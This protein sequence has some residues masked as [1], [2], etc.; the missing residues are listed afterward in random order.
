ML[1]LEVIVPSVNRAVA[2]DAEV[3]HHNAGNVESVF[4]PHE[5]VHQHA[6]TY[7]ARFLLDRIL[8][9]AIHRPIGAEESFSS[10]LLRPLWTDLPHHE[11]R[12][13]DQPIRWT[14]LAV[15]LMLPG[16][17]GGLLGSFLPGFSSELLEFLGKQCW[18]IRHHLLQVEKIAHDSFRLA[19]LQT[20]RHELRGSRAP[21]QQ[22]PGFCWRQNQSAVRELRN[23]GVHLPRHAQIVQ[24]A[25]IQV[26]EEKA[27][28]WGQTLSSRSPPLHA[29]QCSQRAFIGRPSCKLGLGFLHLWCWVQ[30]PWQRLWQRLWP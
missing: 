30:W 12:R 2:E 11:I 8:R 28:S 1:Y 19:V 24:A 15:V 27:T 26:E 16:D 21:V 4:V 3:V 13:G 20:L 10:L 17:D 5:A 9:S 18:D 7:H 29:F 14:L 25:L 22:V 6:V 23:H